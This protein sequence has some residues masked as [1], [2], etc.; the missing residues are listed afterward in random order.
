MLYTATLIHDLHCLSHMHHLFVP[1]CDTSI[2]DTAFALVSDRLLEQFTHCLRARVHMRYESH[3]HSESFFVAVFTF[4]V[5]SRGVSMVSL[6]QF[7][8]ASLS[9]RLI[10]VSANRVLKYLIV[11]VKLGVVLGLY[12]KLCVRTVRQFERLAF[13]NTHILRVCASSS[14]SKQ[15]RESEEYIH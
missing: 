13:V 1:D 15:P 5:V 3:E 6:F 10:Q 2:I 12:L 4:K 14:T 8:G 11:M 7:E 9:G